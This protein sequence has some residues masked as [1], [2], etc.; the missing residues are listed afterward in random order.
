MANLH[1]R[2]IID[3]IQH[4]TFKDG[5]FLNEVI[6]D[7]IIKGNNIGFSIDISGKNKLEAEE[8][9]LKAMNKLNEISEVNKITIVF[10]EI[11]PMEKKVQK[12]KHFVENVKKII[13]VASGK[14]GVGKSTISALIAQQLSLA[15]YRVGIVDADIY[16]PSIPHIFGINEVPQ[17]KDGR[18][19][20]V[21]AQ[22]IE[23]ISIG[24]LVKDRSAI[25]WRGPMASKTIYQLLSVT[26]WD[27]LDYLII[28]MPPGT[29]DI[30]LS[31]LENYHLDGVIIV[32][33][34]QKISE[35]DVIRSIDLYQKLNLPILGIIENMSYMLKN[36][37]GGH[38]SQKY[39]IPLIA[40]I[41]ITPQIA[42]ACDKS[43]PL[44]NLLTLPLEKYLQ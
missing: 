19:I 43:L 39:N 40:Q 22:S 33:T 30:H 37:S 44:T 41:P 24:F 16:G 2:Q 32:T 11:K 27:N 4:I 9:R 10:T 17:T 34:P 1:Q 15:N 5:T 13:L 3:K 8:I 38:L 29:G 28:D 14:G 36:N 42:E 23:I 7:I 20:P 12:P 25:I 26:K 21:L 31:I 18:I 6:S 35:I